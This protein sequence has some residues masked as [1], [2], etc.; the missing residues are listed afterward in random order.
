MTER[1]RLLYSLNTAGS[2][3]EKALNSAL[4]PKLSVFAQ[5]FYGYPGLNMFE[6]MMRHKWGLYT[7]LKVCPGL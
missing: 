3:K 7:L 6:D 4:I 5:G 2:T 1:V